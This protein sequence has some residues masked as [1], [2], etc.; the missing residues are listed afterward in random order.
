MGGTPPQSPHSTMTIQLGTVINVASEMA[1]NQEILPLVMLRKRVGQS[2][3]NTDLRRVK[4]SHPS[5][6]SFANKIHL[7]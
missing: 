1:L 4:Q 3:R 2:S 7:C 6:I 5:S